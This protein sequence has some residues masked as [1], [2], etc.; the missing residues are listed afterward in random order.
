MTTKQ[1]TAVIIIMAVM[2][3]SIIGLAIG[4]VLVARQATVSNSMTVSYEAKHVNATIN[5]TA[6]LYS[7]ASTNPEDADSILMTHGDK[8]DLDEVEINF[9]ANQAEASDT[10]VFSPQEL[11]ATGRAEYK[12]T[13]TNTAHPSNPKILKVKANVLKVNADST[14]SEI[15]KVADNVNVVIS[16]GQPGTAIEGYTHYDYVG[17]GDNSITFYVS[18]S[19]HDASAP[20]DAFK[21]ALGLELSYELDNPNDELLTVEVNYLDREGYVATPFKTAPDIFFVSDPN[22]SAPKLVFIPDIY[23]MQ[24]YTATPAISSKFG[25]VHLFTTTGQKSVTTYNMP[26]SKFMQENNLTNVLFDIGFSW[27]QVE[28]SSEEMLIDFV[29]YDNQNNVLQSGSQSSPQI[30]FSLLSFEYNDLSIAPFKLV[31]NIQSTTAE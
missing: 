30:N 22:P 18:I 16:K 2:V 24:A 10:V 28:G 15:D 13:I 25:N 23:I 29:L 6:L 26:S 19:V 9:F 31:V 1:K 21:M 14:T 8:T 12:F 3:L 17:Y 7:T 20:I 5:T 4:I 27:E 11:T